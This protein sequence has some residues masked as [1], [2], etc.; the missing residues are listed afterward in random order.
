MKCKLYYS[1]HCPESVEAREILMDE[2]IN[3]DFI[4][5]TDSMPNL[6]EFLNIRDKYSFFDKVRED[7][8][9]GVPTLVFGENE[10]FLNLEDGVDLEEVR[11]HL[12]K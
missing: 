7:N 8:R 1:T 11:S 12:N 6:K 9:V 10:I 5:I 4:N 2:D 3:M